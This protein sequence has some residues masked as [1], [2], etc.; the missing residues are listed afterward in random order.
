MLLMSN[1]VQCYYQ[2]DRVLEALDIEPRPPFPEGHDVEQ[3]DWSL[4]DP[5]RARDKFYRPV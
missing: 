1:I 5:V 2:D 4:L 3:G